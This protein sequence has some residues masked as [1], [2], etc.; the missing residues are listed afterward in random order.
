MKKLLFPNAYYMGKGILREFANIV[1][2][3]GTK[4]VFIGSKSGLKAVQSSVSECMENAAYEYAFIEC[5]KMCCN[6]EKK[7][8]MEMD[9]VKNAETLCAVG[10]GGCMD[11]VRFVAFNLNKNLIMIPTSAS[12]DAPCTQISLTY[13]EDGSQIIEEFFHHRCPDMIVVD[14]QIIAD[15]PERLIAAGM[16]DAMAT[17]YECLTCYNNKTAGESI[18]ETAVVLS[19]GATNI[20]KKHG[21]AAYDAV[22]EGV[23]TKDLENVIE[24]NC[25]LSS[26]GGVNSGCACAHGFGDWLASVHKGHDY[27]HGERV[28]VGLVV[29][30]ILEGYPEQEIKDMVAFGKRVNLPV[31]VADVTDEDVKDVAKRAAKELQTDHFMINL[32][33][34]FSE[35][36]VEKAILY[37]CELAK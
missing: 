12:S 20:I 18:T 1:K 35:T 10:G 14:T 31:C 24:A 37:A 21:A 8:L 33:C 36:V 2:P 15:A 7:R 28:M 34:D 6:S 3:Y 29:Q 27:L 26:M 13:S 22:K 5:K 4:F 9:I 17:R 25:F 19:E 23:V 16:G 30:M 32:N 11:L